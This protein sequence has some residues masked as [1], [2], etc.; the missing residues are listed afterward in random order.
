M[1]IV[2]KRA[3][4]MPGPRDEGEWR[5]QIEHTNDN[6][7]IER[8]VLVMPADA[9]EW[10]I[11]QFNVDAETAAK[12]IMT[13]R[14]TGVKDNVYDDEPTRSASRSLALS[15]M[16]EALGDGAI[17]W[18]AEAASEPVAGAIV[19]S[20]DG[21]PLTTLIENSP[22]DDE[23]IA[24]KREFLDAARGER[25]RRQVEQAPIEDAASGPRL[26]RPAPDELRER[27]LPTPPAE[28]ASSGPAWR[29]PEE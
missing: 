11:A 23:H 21:D 15:H 10:R 13:R 6:G 26:R 5:L 25:R 2:V 12:L 3:V 22:V 16:E 18:A 17:T 8:G 28:A 14:F 27:L 1:D 7:E 19:D 9:I 24:V 29:R 20:L 4:L